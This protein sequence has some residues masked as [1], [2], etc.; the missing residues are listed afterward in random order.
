MQCTLK[1]VTKQTKLPLQKVLNDARTKK[2]TGIFM[3]SIK[4]G[5]NSF[6]FCRWNLIKQKEFLDRIL[7]SHS[8]WVY[9]KYQWLVKTLTGLHSKSSRKE[10]LTST[11][12]FQFDFFHFLPVAKILWQVSDR[13]SHIISR[14]L[15]C[16]WL[17]NRKLPT[18]L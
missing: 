14:R 7:N 11:N 1:T 13:K 17:Q 4:S 5:L 16:L 10:T 15:D 3:M 9:M 12:Y 6:T 18:Y 2:T 8:C